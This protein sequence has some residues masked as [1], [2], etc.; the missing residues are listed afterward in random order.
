M[1]Y[2]LIDISC[3]IL[4]ILVLTRIKDGEHMNPP[5]KKRVVID[6]VTIVYFGQCLNFWI[7]QDQQH[8]LMK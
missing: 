6:S 8:I 2:K 4:I 3:L 1:E 5:L 7:S